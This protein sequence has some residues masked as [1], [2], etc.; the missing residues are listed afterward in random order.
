VGEPLAEVGAALL[1]GR[2][3]RGRGLRR[4]ESPRRRSRSGRSRSP[5]ARSAFR[6]PSRT[7][8]DDNKEVGL[9]AAW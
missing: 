8:I 3:L 9:I 5:G 7:P 2:R 4:E 6:W 1:A